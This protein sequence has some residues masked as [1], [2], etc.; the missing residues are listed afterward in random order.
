MNIGNAHFTSGVG[1]DKTTYDI[2]MRL[3]KKTFNKGVFYLWNGFIKTASSNRLTLF[4]MIDED[5]DIE[6]H[7]IK[8][9]T[10]EHVKVVEKIVS[11]K[12]NAL[13]NLK[14]NDQQIRDIAILVLKKDMFDDG[15]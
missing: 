11:S 15:K 8:S 6:V 9:L 7:V 12:R 5:S 1:D 10:E 2:M 3:A 13:L 4:R 14:H